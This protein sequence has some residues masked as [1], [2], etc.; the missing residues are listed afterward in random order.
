MRSAVLCVGVSD[1]D[2]QVQVDGDRAI[3]W[4]FF[5]EECQ[6]KGGD[7]ESVR[8]RFTGRSQA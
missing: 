4:G 1:V 2:A 3:L 7:P 6:Y 8:V 5:T